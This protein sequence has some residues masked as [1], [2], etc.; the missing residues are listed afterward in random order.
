MW[1]YPGLKFTDQQVYELQVLQSIL[2]GQGGRLFIELRTKFPCL[3]GIT[4][5]NGGDRGWLLRDIYRLQPREVTK[6][7]AM[8]KQELKKLAD[9]LVSNEELQRSK[10]YLIGRHDIELQ[11]PVVLQRVFF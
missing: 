10:R 8:M 3:L 9:E 7:I 11:K 2:A 4:I 6:A 1:V 5:E